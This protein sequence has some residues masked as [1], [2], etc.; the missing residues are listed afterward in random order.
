MS[1]SLRTLATRA[2][3]S[4]LGGRRLLHGTPSRAWDEVRPQR[5]PNE[6]L[7]P[8]LHPPQTVSIIGAPMTCT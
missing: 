3:R 1:T 4:A 6:I 2:S 8:H 7:N 5:H